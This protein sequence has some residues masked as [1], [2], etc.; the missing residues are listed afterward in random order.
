MGHY[1]ITGAATGIGAAIKTRLLAENHRITTIDIRDADFLIDLSDVTERQTRLAE[2]AA[3]DAEYDGIITCAG[4]ASHFPDTARIA[5]I[6]FFGSVEVV[7]TL[8]P[9]LNAGAKIITISSNSA[10]Q[11]RN[12][13]LV[14][15]MLAGDEETSRQLA[16]SG[17]GHEAY[18]FSKLAIARW[19]RQRAPA[20]ASQGMTINAIAPGYIET[21]MTLAVAESEEYGAAIR[22]FVKSIPIGRPGQPEDVSNLVQFLLSPAA[23][24]MTGNVVFL[25]GGH[26]ALFRP[27][28]I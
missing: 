25:D 3:Q 4:V 2:L 28:A 13:E 15:A 1:L 16:S 7:E 11:S 24:F 26:D 18:A 17:S 23:D 5:A 20:L 14:A 8:L 21:P 12:G 6:N 27:E 10:P 19:V 22:D 9:R